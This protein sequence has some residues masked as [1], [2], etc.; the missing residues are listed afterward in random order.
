MD[1]KYIKPILTLPF[2]MG[3]ILW[4]PDLGDAILPANLMFATKLEAVHVRDGQPFKYLDLGSGLVTNSGVAFM[5]DDFTDGSTDISSLDH[6][7]VGIGTTAAA[8]GDTTLENV[9]GMPARV[10][11]TPSNPAAPDYRTVAT[12]SFTG[13]HAITEWGLFSAVTGGTMWDRKVF[14]AVNVVNG[15]SIQFTYTLTMNSGG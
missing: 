1:R 10:A 2:R 11:G 7:A 13:T 4:T 5:A 12:V 8:V 3:K 14:A 6:H 15:D 9:T